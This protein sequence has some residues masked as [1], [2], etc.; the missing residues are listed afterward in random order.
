MV[1]D[2]RKQDAND[3]LYSI[4]AIMDY[5]PETLLPRIKA[6]VLAINSAD[7]GVNP[8]ELGVTEREISKITGARFVLL[9]IGPNTVGHLTYERA[10]LWKAELVRALAD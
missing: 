6:R 3:A 10:A 1:E 7:D 5:A 4:E 8:A 2:A 9:P